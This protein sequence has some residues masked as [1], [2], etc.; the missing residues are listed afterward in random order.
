MKERPILFSGEMVRAILEGRKTQTRRP[1]KTQPPARPDGAGTPWSWRRVEAVGKWFH[2]VSE[3]PAGM[4]T[5]SPPLG[6]VGDRLWVRETWQCV[7]VGQPAPPR[8]SFK[9]PDSLP[10]GWD[11]LYSASGDVCSDSVGWR[12][13][14]HM[15][16]WASRIDLEITA[17]RVERVQE[18]NRG[19]A[20]EEGCPF[21]N[22]AEGPSPR[23]WFRDLWQ[24]IYGT[25]DENLFVWVYEFRRLK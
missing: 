25:W 9:I 18:I 13:S 7:P 1:M 24:S 22:M 17:V 11:V 12:P 21:A 3:K 23:D 4:F 5:V 16:R 8:G 20:M 14:I 2:I 6:T 15:P 19:D 10:S